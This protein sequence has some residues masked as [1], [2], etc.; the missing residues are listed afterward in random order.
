M[1]IYFKKE[2]GEISKYIEIGEVEEYSLQRE[3]GEIRSIFIKRK[4]PCRVDG[5]Q[6]YDIVTPY[7]YGGPY[8]CHCRE[9]NKE[10]LIKE[11]ETYFGEFCEYQKIVS[12]FV[13]FHPIIN[14]GVDFQKIYDSECIR[15]TIGTNLKD[16]DDPITEEFSKS[17]RKRIRRALRDGISYRIKQSPNDIS[18]FKN[19]YYSTMNRNNA[20]DYYYFSDE[21]FDECLKYFKNNIILVEAIYEEKTIA[22]GLYFI[23]DK[24][25]HIHL[26][27]TLSEYLQLSPAYILRYAVTLWGKENGYELI[28]HGGGRSNSEED[29]LYQFK[30]QFGEK[31]SFDFYVGKKIWNKRAYKQ[32]CETMNVDK[33]EEFFP[34][35]RKI[36]R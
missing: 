22:A 19:V 9:E 20:S 26:S 8:I 14:N 18:I 23:W 21:Y 5:E 12:E 24:T 7:G 15:Q 3:Y 32:L 25:I 10:K 2:Y 29:S 35:Y 33:N 11:Y 36:M 4:I 34:A 1:D 13:R 31:T 27:G 28:H 16:Y 30:K 6:Y 17:C